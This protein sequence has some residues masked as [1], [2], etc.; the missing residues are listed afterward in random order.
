MSDELTIEGRYKVVFTGMSVYGV[1]ETKLRENLKEK[2]Q[3]PM[4]DLNALFSAGNVTI[5]KNLSWADARRYQ[6]RLRELGALCEIFPMED[7]ADSQ[8]EVPEI[9]CP[10]CMEPQTGSVCSNCGFDIR[11]YRQHLKARGYIELPDNGYKLER[12]HGER[13]SGSDRREGVRFEEGRRQ[14]G[15][16]RMNPWESGLASGSFPPFW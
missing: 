8:G 7:F 14:G 1:D 10:E 5:Q 2:L 11:T 15:D 3:L 13:R 9:R 16:R 4:E 6:E 12:R